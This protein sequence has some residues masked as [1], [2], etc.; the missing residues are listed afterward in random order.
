MKYLLPLS[1]IVLSFV[2]AVWYFMPPIFCL[3]YFEGLKPTYNLSCILEEANRRGE[4]ALEKAFRAATT[5]PGPIKIRYQD[6]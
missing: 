4:T 2:C 3:Q 6:L 5:T 1:L